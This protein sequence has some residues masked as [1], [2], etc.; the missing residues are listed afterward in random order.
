MLNRDKIPLVMKFELTYCNNVKLH[1][2]QLD[3]DKR[4][5]V[6]VRELYTKGLGTMVLLVRCK[7]IMTLPSV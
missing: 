2:R 1:L 5:L 3:R 6:E 7:N 4:P